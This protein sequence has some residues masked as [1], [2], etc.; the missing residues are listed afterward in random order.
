MRSS[1]DQWRR[2]L[3]HAVRALRRAPGFTVM[4]VGTLGLAIGVNAGMFSVVNKV[5]LDPLPYPNADRLLFIS[6]SAPGSDLQG[7]FGVANEFFVQYKEQARLLEDLSTFNSFTSTMRA[8]DR[9]ERIR[10]S[11]PTSSL[12]TTL[13]ARPIRGRLPT[14][15]DEDRV[16]VIS[17]A[18]WMSWFGGDEGVIG[19]TYDISG[20]TR[21]V[22]GVMGPEFRFPSDETLVWVSSEI[23]PEGITPG[24]FGQPLVGRMV[25]GATPETVAAELNALA[26][27]LPERFGGSANYARLIG[28]HRAVVRPLEDELLGRVARPLWVL[29]AAVGIVLLIAS[30]N[31]ANLFL[32]RAEGRQRDLAIRRA[33]GAG[34]GQLVRVQMSEVVVVA[35]LAGLLALVL[36]YFALQGFVRAAPA[37]IPRLRDVA[38]SPMTLLFTLGAAVLSALACGA[39]PALRASSSDFTRLRDGSRGSTRQRHWARNG[40]VVG[41]TALALVLLIGSA[42]LVRSFWALRS[43]D[44]GYET[45]DLFTFQIAPEGPHLPDGPAYARFSLQFMDRLRALPGVESVGLVENIP[46]NEGTAS[47]RFLAEGAAV[48]ADGGTRLQV[49]FAA[50]DYF[51]AMG[52][53]VAAGRSF[54]TNDHLSPLRHVV[55]SRSAAA[56]LWPGQ[57]AIGKR[58]QRPGLPGWDTVIGVVDDVRQNNFR[59]RPNPLLYYP[60]VGPERRSWVISSPAYVLKTTRAETIA[61]EVRAIVREMAPE[62]PMYRVY[63]MA[64][65]AATSMV[66]VS[67]TMLTLGVASALALILGVVG[68]YGIL[69]YVVAERTREIGVRLALGAQ[70]E[71]VRRMVVAQGS[72]VVLIGVLI[73]IAAAVGV[74]RAL[75]SLL[76]GV[77]AVDA[78]TFASMSVSMIAIGLLASYLPARRA[79][80]IDPMVLLR[81]E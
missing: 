41:Q 1:L 75:G 2:D 34:R 78:A 55:I 80:R 50:G 61:A 72:R 4:T 51:K 20:S 48:E 31:V 56:L 62:A 47:A 53:D 36:A 60:L 40:L 71:Q 35:S 5:L 57:D 69:S 29:L 44:P 39:L 16:A 77:A 43:V 30:A 21:T 15:A 24:R 38:M 52:I 76:F 8:G 65:L 68:L 49:T 66:D 25:P 26:L 33:I 28:Q 17:H 18:L 7:E 22:V 73:G 59:D 58:L 12:F 27:R 13:G 23:R 64:G 67:F 42:L 45:R 32:V 19:R 10:M 11:Q 81:P 70:A 54:D 74:T 6:A 3:R 63:T 46:L 37:G 14:A 9:V 79:S